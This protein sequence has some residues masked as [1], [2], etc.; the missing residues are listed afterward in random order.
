[1]GSRPRSV[2]RLA[3]ADFVGGEEGEQN[4]QAIHRAEERADY[5][6]ERYVL[7]LFVSHFVRGNRFVAKL[8]IEAHLATN[9]YRELSA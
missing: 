3:A 9:V 6:A 5:G 8:T 7:F 4:E 1:M 2:G